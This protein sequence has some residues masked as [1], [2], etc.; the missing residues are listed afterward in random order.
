MWRGKKSTSLRITMM[1]TAFLEESQSNRKSKKYGQSLATVGILVAALLGQ[2]VHQNNGAFSLIGILFIAIAICISATSLFNF[3]G[4]S[5]PSSAEK[6][7]PL[8]ALILG[9]QFIQLITNP[10]GVYIQVTEQDWMIFVSLVISAAFLTA[11]SLSKEP[12]FG[13]FG[14]A[15]V[16]LVFVGLVLWILRASPTPQIDVFFFQRDSV[17]KLLKLENPYASGFLNIYGHSQFYAPGLVKDGILQF[18]YP[19][20]P[21]DLIAVIP[22]YFLGDVR[23]SQAVAICFTGLIFARFQPGPL[24]RGLAALYW[25]SPRTLFV[26]EQSWIEPLI[27]F[28]AAL[29]IFCLNKFPKSAGWAAGLL[30]ASKQ[31][32]IWMPFL[33]PLLFIGKCKKWWRPLSIALLLAAATCIPFFIW[34]PSAFWK[35][36][37][38]LQILQPFR[39]DALSFSA[40]FNHIGTSGIHWSISFP[41]SIA[42]IAI[43][44]WKSPRTSAG[45]AMATCF[46]YMVFFAFNKQAFC[47]Y[48]FM[49][50]GFACLSA[51]SVQFGEN[52]KPPADF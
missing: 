43:A 8:V 9:V 47:N 25:F 42:C 50:I 27:V 32:M 37:V 30:L 36:A 7:V 13:R 48:Y 6:L 19:Y 2:A 52:E 49:V 17:A 10:P 26:I 24:G 38:Y 35:S 18:G 23:I 34:N 22:A 14:V 11:A 31:T 40:L 45:W 29:L 5:E 1:S 41:A 3:S 15:L 46:T 12:V 21:L 51:A 16:L 28:F 33:L 4:F 39:P 20:L 44:Y